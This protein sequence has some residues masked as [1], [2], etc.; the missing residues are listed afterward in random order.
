M[1]ALSSALC[2]AYQVAGIPLLTPT[3]LE[4][5]LQNRR[6]SKWKV[7]ERAFLYP[8]AL[9]SASRRP[10]SGVLLGM[11][12]RWMVTTVISLHQPWRLH[13]PQDNK[14]RRTTNQSRQRRTARRTDTDRCM[15]LRR[16]GR[17]RSMAMERTGMGI[18][19]GGTDKAGI[20]EE[21]M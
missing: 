9:L 21:G 13:F 11:V 15:I 1:P 8:P 6:L 16:L 20:G 12:V 19:R 7:P 17:R 3:A 4:L 10:R 2:P 14:D 18:Q 5:P